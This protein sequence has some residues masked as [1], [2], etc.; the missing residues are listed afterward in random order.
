MKLIDGQ[1]FFNKSFEKYLASPTWT[2]VAQQQGIRAPSEIAGVEDKPAYAHISHSRIVADCPNCNN[3]EF[4]WRDGPYIMA[5]ANC[6]NAD[7]G[8][9]LRVVIMPE[10]LGGIEELLMKRP[11]PATRN[12]IPGETLEQLEAENEERLV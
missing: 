7:I 2:K 12:W 8:N 1:S 6:G 4:V 10:I 5:C 9:K 3:A 11:N